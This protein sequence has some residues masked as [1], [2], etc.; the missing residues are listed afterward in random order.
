MKSYPWLKFYP[1]LSHVCGEILEMFPIV[2][3]V[4]MCPCNHNLVSTQGLNCTRDTLHMTSLFIPGG[5]MLSLA[6]SY[7]MVK[8]QQLNSNFGYIVLL[9]TRLLIQSEFRHC[10][11]TRLQKRQI[12]CKEYTEIM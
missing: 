1:T 9:K 8:I 12:S 11:A 4:S 2:F 10:L 3:K 5:E 6:L 7:P